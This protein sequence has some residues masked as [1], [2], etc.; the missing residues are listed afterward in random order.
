VPREI[1]GSVVVVTGA[2]SGIGRAAARL[3]AENGARVVLAV[4]RDIADEEA[5]RALARRSVEE[6][7]RIDTW[8]NNAGVWPM[9]ASRTSR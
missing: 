3:F 6:F 1:E 5:V 8:V 4:P 2:S 7:G 9:V